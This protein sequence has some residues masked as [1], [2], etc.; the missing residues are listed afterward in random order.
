MAR[1]TRFLLAALVMIVPL[2]QE[3]AHLGQVRLLKNSVVLLKIPNVIYKDGKPGFA[4]PVYWYATVSGASELGKVL[5]NEDAQWLAAGFPSLTERKITGIKSSKENGTT[6]VT[7]KAKN[8]RDV[9]LTFQGDAEYLFALIAVSTASSK[10]LRENA[11]QAIADRAF[12]GS[13]ASIPSQR[14][15]AMIAVADEVVRAQHIETITFKDKQYL[16]LDLGG[17]QDIYNDLRLNQAQRM[18]QAISDHFLPVIRALAPLFKEGD[19]VYGL[20]LSGTVFHMNLGTYEKLGSNRL[21]LLSPRDA[22]IK[23]FDAELTNQQL[24]NDSIILVDET[25]IE[26]RLNGNDN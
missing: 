11:Y 19:E 17:V 15:T 3:D 23:F 10:G 7:L 6:E 5:V 26:V 16:R 22:I 2:A 14:K 9:I 24:M 18:A 4:R 25:R 1:M 13:L 8:E 21:D 12:T 20:K